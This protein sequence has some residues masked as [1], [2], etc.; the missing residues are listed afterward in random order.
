MNAMRLQSGTS[1]LCD[2]ILVTFAATHYEDPGRLDAGDTAEVRLR[3]LQGQE[4]AVNMPG[5]AGPDL[6]DVKNEGSHGKSLEAW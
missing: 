3:V 1:M 4:Q 2:G 6:L 5:V